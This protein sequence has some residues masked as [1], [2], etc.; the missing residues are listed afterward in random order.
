MP[1][2]MAGLVLGCGGRSWRLI[3]EPRSRRCVR[4]LGSTP[5]AG[6]THPKFVGHS[7]RLQR[8]LN[9]HKEE[10]DAYH[11]AVQR[12]WATEPQP[13]C[14]ALTRTGVAFTPSARDTYGY[15]RRRY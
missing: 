6:W 3:S 14:A 2:E 10:N 1:V 11:A 12:A 15:T 13:I 8:L 9:D 4:H 7:G 5:Y